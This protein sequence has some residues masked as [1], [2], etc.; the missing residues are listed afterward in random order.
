[1]RGSLSGILTN[2]NNKKNLIGSA[3]IIEIFGRG[4]LLIL[5]IV[6]A[7][8]YKNNVVIWL[9]VFYSLNS[10]IDC[11]EIFEVDIL[12]N[13]KGSFL[14]KVGIMESIWYF[15]LTILLLKLKAPLLAFGSIAFLRNLFKATLIIFSQHTNNIFF[16]LKSASFNSSLKLLKR[17][18][19]FILSTL[20]IA[21]ALKIDQVMIGWICGMEELGQYSIAVKVNSSLYFLPTILSQTF[22]PLVAENVK[23]KSSESILKMYKYAWLMGLIMTLLGVFIFSNLIPYIFGNEFTKAKTALM[24]LSPCSFFVAIGCAQGVWYN[25]NNKENLLAK[26]TLLSTII[27]IA[28]NFVLLPFMGSYGAGISTTLSSALSVFLINYFDD[29]FTKNTNIILFPWKL[30]TS[31]FFD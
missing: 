26:R 13:K 18:L 25:V 22:I 9:I 7:L 23:T 16:I 11:I 2:S 15:L 27:N 5:T 6:F 31:E 19:P 1:M 21:V 10:F 3:L 14:G 8:L 12:N 24:F 20:S 30:K 28:I 4:I 29:N 17:G